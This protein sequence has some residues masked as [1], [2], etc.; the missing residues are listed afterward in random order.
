[1]PCSVYIHDLNIFNLNIIRPFYT[2]G[3]Q[4]L[5]DGTIISSQFILTAAHCLYKK[6][7]VG[8]RV[9]EYRATGTA[10]AC[11]R[12]SRNGRNCETNTQVLC[13]AYSHNCLVGLVNKRYLLN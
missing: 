8:V 10:A 7:P 11:A 12:A 6:R 9:G 13:S 3:L 4:Y 1:M 5:C 2:D